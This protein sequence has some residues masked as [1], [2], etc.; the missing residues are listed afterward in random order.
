MEQHWL[1]KQ[2]NPDLLIFALGWG[3]DPHAVEGIRPSGC[4]ILCL[5]DYRS[6]APVDPQSVVTYRRVWL[7]SW[8]F[9]VWASELVLRDIHFYRTVALNGTPLPINNRYGIPS[10][11]FRVTLE[12][13]K[14]AGTDTFNRRTYGASYD[15]LARWLTNRS[16]TEKLTE[17][18]TLFDLSTKAYR[19]A[20]RWDEAV[21]GSR[22]QIFSPANMQA[23]WQDESP[24]TEVEIVADMPH[25][26]FGDP[27]VVLRRINAQIPGQSHNHE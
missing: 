6:I 26:P 18:Q 21:I 1:V 15:S 25:Y 22:D 3:C 13:M 23:Y 10:K 11:I 2:N 5:Y 20:I 17:L 16:E 19:L 12:G 9:G 7:F 14:T 4:D 8:S 24:S 27:N